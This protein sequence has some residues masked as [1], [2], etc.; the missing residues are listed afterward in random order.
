MPPAP[1]DRL[2]HPSRSAHLHRARIGIVALAA[3]GKER[4]RELAHRPLHGASYHTSHSAR[5]GYRGPPATGHGCHAR[6]SCL[7]IPGLHATVAPACTRTRTRPGTVAR[8]AHVL[9]GQKQQITPSSAHRPSGP[10]STSPHVHC[11][12]PPSSLRPE[13]HPRVLRAPSPSIVH[14][15]GN[16]R[17]SAPGLI[18][19]WTGCTL[20]D[21]S[22]VSAPAFQ[23]GTLAE[24][25]ARDPRAWGG[26][27]LFISS[28][29]V[30]V[31]LC[32]SVHAVPTLFQLPSPMSS[33]QP[34]RTS[35]LPV[36]A[37]YGLMQAAGVR[38]GTGGTFPAH[39][40]RSR[41]PHAARCTLHAAPAR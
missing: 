16:A 34:S 8:N 18:Q 29:G 40:S 1:P 35:T 14:H 9:P 30:S 12:C 26:E 38:R 32:M 37:A 25:G 20:S 19:I 17:A 11:R 23:R 3:A 13:K 21:S 22:P 5:W 31:S 36:P 28:R 15:N 4:N 10:H 27:P 7:R 41:M 2:P 33:A 24:R 6:P 39:P